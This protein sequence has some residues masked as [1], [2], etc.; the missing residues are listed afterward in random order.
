MKD[1]KLRYTLYYYYKVSGQIVKTYIL[2][3]NNGRT[4]LHTTDKDKVRITLDLI[5]IN[6]Y[7]KTLRVENGLN[8]RKRYYSASIEY[9]EK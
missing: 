8:V 7:K 5:G 6:N 9:Y 1:E 4:I 3:D 2:I